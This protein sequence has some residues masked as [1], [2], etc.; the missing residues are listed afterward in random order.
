MRGSRWVAFRA[1][2][3]AAALSLGAL[4]GA[5]RADVVMP[6]KKDCPEGSFAYDVHLNV[7]CDP[8]ACATD[9]DCEPFA[10]GGQAMT[11]RPTPLCIADEVMFSPRSRDFYRKPVAVGP[12]GDSCV[13]PAKCDTAN[14]CV[15]RP[16]ADEEQARPD[17]LPGSC[18]CALVP[19]APVT[20]PHLA[21]LLGACALLVARRT[22]C[23]AG[24]R[25]RRR[26]GP[27]RRPHAA[28]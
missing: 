17:Q 3:V 12:C 1:A 7:F 27:D 19:A 24:D 23:T 21:A 20:G 6:L 11:C 4:Q 22:R 5:A 9:A 16:P 15:P 2:G 8:A 26:S 10:R 28:P 25:A 18:R 14:R 13:A